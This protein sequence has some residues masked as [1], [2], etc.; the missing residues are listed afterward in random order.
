MKDHIW[1][2]ESSLPK[3]VEKC[4]HTKQNRK[5]IRT[6]QR[7]TSHIFNFKNLDRK[8]TKLNTEHLKRWKVSM[9]DLK[10]SMG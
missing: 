10:Y 8:K 3:N 6:L 1:C 7:I 2:G 9:I 4:I 5:I